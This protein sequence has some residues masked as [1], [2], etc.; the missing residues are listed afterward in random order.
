MMARRGEIQA[1]RAAVRLGIPYCM[2][3]YA[4]CSMS[5]VGNSIQ[6]P[7]W[8]QLNMFKDRVFMGELLKTATQFCSALIFNIDLPVLGTRYRDFKSGLAG[9]TLRTL[10]HRSVQV[11]SRP[12]WSWDVGLRGM[13]HALGNIQPYMDS[14]GLTEHSSVWT[15]ANLDPAATWRDLAWVRENW[16]GPLI[17]KGVLHPEDAQAAIDIGATAIV[18]SNHG[19]RQLDSVVSTA[20]ALPAIAQRVNGRATIFVDGGSDPESTY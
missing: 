2:S 11:V 17:I 15:K 20:A 6:V 5:E 3:T 1:A 19:G 10:L 9:P 14:H 4:I 12:A 7:F 8:Y 18:V 13:P 16:T